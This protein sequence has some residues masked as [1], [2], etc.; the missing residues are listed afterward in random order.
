MTVKRA[1]LRA[2]VRKTGLNLFNVMKNMNKPE[3]CV[4]LLKP[5]SLDR[6]IYDALV[7]SKNMCVL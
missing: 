2:S 7:A 1:S 3:Q 4:I 6:Q 5:C